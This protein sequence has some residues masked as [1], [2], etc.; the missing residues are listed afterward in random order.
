MVRSCSFNSNPTLTQRPLT[1]RQERDL[2]VEYITGGQVCDVMNVAKSRAHGAVSVNNNLWR[3][4]ERPP[5][6]HLPHV[7]VRVLVAPFL[8]SHPHIF[9]LLQ[10][11]TYRSNL[12][13]SF[14]V[15]L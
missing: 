3:S 8:Q 11:S 9:R 7:S 1:D 4:V 10:G 15:D 5:R 12:S 13:L 14:N 6:T 2:R